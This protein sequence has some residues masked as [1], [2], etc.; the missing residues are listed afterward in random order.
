MVS[1]VG[2]GLTKLDRYYELS[3]KDL[4]SEAYK[5][6]ITKIKEYDQPDIVIVSSGYIDVLGKNI[7]SSY[8][9]S[10]GLGL[11]NTK[12][13]RIENGDNGGASILTAYSF[14]KS[15]VAKKVLLIGIDKFSDYPSKYVN[16]YL[17]YN[18]DNDYTYHVGIT[19]HAYSA[20]LMKRYMK[21]YNVDYEYFTKWPIK[22]HQNAS[23]NP[24]A[25][26][27]F[28][29]DKNTVVNS[30]IVSD[31]LRIFDVGARADGAS[32]VL[33]TADE[34]AKRYFDSPVKIDGIVGNIG[35]MNLSD[36][37]LPSVAK[38]RNCLLYTSPSPRYRRQR[39]MCIR[40][41][42]RGK[43]LDVVDSLDINLSGG[44]KARGYIGGGTAI[45]QLGEVFLHLTNQFKGKSANAE[46][47]IILS[48]DDLGN[49]SYLAVLSR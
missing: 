43:G 5:Q 39:Q 24:L 18:L 1:I 36:P 41:R 22:M 11:Q 49:T 14:I 33:V 4:V 21:K 34:V 15:G 25:Y 3:E 35:A 46:K 31:P 48:N 17:S 28:K 6:L 8:K 40:D 30:Q 27:K 29:V 32:V 37:S 38:A 9:I 16:E 2:C 19:P 20:L 42:E 23:E 26:L 45:Y 44:L 12:V 10:S 13:M 7:L 47:G